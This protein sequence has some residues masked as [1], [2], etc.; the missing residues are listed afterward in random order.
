MRA[1]S[2]VIGVGAA[3]CFNVGCRPVDA[4]AETGVAC[5][6]DPVAQWAEIDSCQDP[7]LLDMAIA[8][9]TYRGQPV[10]TATQSPPEPTSTDWCADLA[11]GPSGITFLNLPRDPPK[12]LGAYLVLQ[13]DD[14][15]ADTTGSYGALVTSSDKT[16]IEFSRTCLTRF[17][18]TSSDCAQFGDAFARFGTGLGGVKETT[19]QNATNGGCLCAYTVEADAAGSNLSGR[20]RRRGSVMTFY[21]SNMVLPTQVDYCI[22]GDR[23][24]LSGHDRT[25]ILDIA[26]LRTMTLDRIVCGN[27]KL[28]RGEQCDPPDQTT[29]SAMCQKIGAP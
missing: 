4:C 3:L 7:A 29:C 18:Y 6:G 24:T 5:G 19:C 25:N 22:D 9:R 14:P 8:K 13:G 15:P 16:S 12:L 11:Y 23:M 20:W 2:A 17:G 28:E 10:V 1:H 21:P 27:G 26:G